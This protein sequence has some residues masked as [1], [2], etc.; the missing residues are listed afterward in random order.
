MNWLPD[1]FPLPSVDAGTFVNT[2]AATTSGVTAESVL[3]A[4]KRFKEQFLTPPRQVVIKVTP[5]LPF[6][7]EGKNGEPE[8]VHVIEFNPPRSN[9]KIFYVSKKAKASVDAEFNGRNAIAPTLSSEFPRC[10]F[11]SNPGMDVAEFLDMDEPLIP[12]AGTENRD[13]FRSLLLKMGPF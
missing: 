7:S 8:T 6:E 13:E 2:N 10:E 1:D 9:L 4:M 5:M 11:C 12:G 3:A